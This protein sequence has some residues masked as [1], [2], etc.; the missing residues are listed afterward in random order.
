[1]IYCTNCGTKLPDD[2]AFCT[3]CGA[4]IDAEVG[5]EE[6]NRTEEPK[7]IQ[8]RMAQNS[9]T[10]QQN[11]T[12]NDTTQQNTT[13][14]NTTGQPGYTYQS[15]YTYQ[16]DK[17]YRP[18]ITY[19][20]ENTTGNPEIDPETAAR[21][22]LKKKKRFPAKLVLVLVAIVAV[23]AGAFAIKKMIAPPITGSSNFALFS[24]KEFVSYTAE[25]YDGI[26]VLTVTVDT[27]GIEDKLDRG[28]FDMSSSDAAAVAESITI[29][30]AETENLSNGQEV[31]MRVSG[32]TEIL[33]EYGII[34][35]ESS[36]AYVVQGLTE[37][38]AINPFDFVDVT[39]TGISP[40]AEAR[41]EAKKV[42]SDFGEL[43][44]EFEESGRLKI[45]DE[46]VLKCMEDETYYLERGYR[47]SEMERSYTVEGVSA[48]IVTEDEI[49]DTA[50]LRMK[51]E[52]EDYIN[53]YLEEEKIDSRPVNNTGLRYLGLL[54]LT[55]KEMES[56]R[57][58]EVILVY[59]TNISSAQLSSTAVYYPYRFYDVVEYSDGTIDYGDK[60]PAYDTDSEVFPHGYAYE[61]AFKGF[62]D[63]TTMFTKLARSRTDEYTYEVGKELESEFE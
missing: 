26:G 37:V 4:R 25:G 42:N 36:Y 57:N 10:V 40:M 8:P 56:D 38:E 31:M 52:A 45:G 43:S 6:D 49:N 15:Q 5:V 3:N 30:P 62:T 58:N 50:L 21:L 39:F 51:K 53:A 18:N 35:K 13:Q 22:K 59:T 20:P 12:Q 47:L 46:V 19:Q 32:D 63:K 28:E 16:P 1:M 2:A 48:Y 34:F 61:S 33:K 29:T 7:T 23:V 54:I 17:T 24:I 41:F 55:K 44:Y 9:A 14:N 27:E 60:G 11:T